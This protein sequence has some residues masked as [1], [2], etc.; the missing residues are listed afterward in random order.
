MTSIELI[1]PDDSEVR[2]NDRPLDPERGIFE[3]PPL[4]GGDLRTIEATAM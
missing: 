2:N 3:G 1:Y 4:R